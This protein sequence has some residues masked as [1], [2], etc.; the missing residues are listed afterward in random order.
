MQQLDS[1]VS[2]EFVTTARIGSLAFVTTIGVVAAIAAV[3]G[4]CSAGDF[5]IVDCFAKLA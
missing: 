3:G 1:V 2:L 5:T 4:R